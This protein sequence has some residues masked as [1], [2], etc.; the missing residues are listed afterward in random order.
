M[1]AFNVTIKFNIQQMVKNGVPK[2]ATAEEIEAWTM[3]ETP[4]SA[5]Q[6]KSTS[7]NKGVATT[8][9]VIEGASEDSVLDDLSVNVPLTGDYEVDVEEI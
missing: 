8:N 2:R 4:F 9:L 5:S 7:V 6:I 3:M 1:P